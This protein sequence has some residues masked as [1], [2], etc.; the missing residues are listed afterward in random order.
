MQTMAKKRFK[1]KVKENEERIYQCIQQNRTVRK[2]ST[3][4]VKTNNADSLTKYICT[5]EQLPGLCIDQ[6]PD[7]I[8]TIQCPPNSMNGIYIPK[9]T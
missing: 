2:N 5:A 8:Q 3:G 6:F 4:T 9:L 1:I 7:T